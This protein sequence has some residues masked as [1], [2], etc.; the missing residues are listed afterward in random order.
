MSV[1]VYI[2]LD[3]F[4][5]S[6]VLAEGNVLTVLVLKGQIFAADSGFDLPNPL[7][8][9]HAEHYDTISLLDWYDI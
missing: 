4:Q 7:V 3:T 5:G 6:I 2:A 9:T 8:G 1:Q